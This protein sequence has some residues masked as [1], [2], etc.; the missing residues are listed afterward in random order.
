MQ[1]KWKRRWQRLAKAILPPMAAGLLLLSVY[2]P[3]LANPTGGTVT[4]GA[5]NI[6]TSGSTTTINQTTN[7]VAINWQSF[8]IGKGETVTFV[9]P[10]ATSV[11]L[12]RVV[13]SDASSIYG[14]LNA[15]GRVYLINPNGIL[16]APG[17]QVNTGGLVA[18]TL[19]ISDSDFMNGN[20]VFEKNGNAGSVINQG[21]ITAADHAVLIG[22]VV[23]N[24]GVIAAQ[25][26]GL[27][28]GDKV[29]LDFNGDKL[30]NVTVNTGALNG[31]AT[32]SG[33]ICADGG[34]VVMSAGTKDALLNTV[35]NN[36][37]VI[38]A[39]SV[40]NV[41]GVIRLEGGT[42]TNRGTLDASG[43][44]SGQTG[45]TVKVLGNTVTLTSGS[46]IDVSGNAGGG[47][48][49]IGGA[50]QCGGSEYTAT[51]TT[52]E[53]GVT[54]TADAITTGNG[55]TVVVWANDTTTFAGTITARGGSVSGNGGNVET[56]G[57]KSLKVSGT[58]LAGATKGKNGSWLLDPEDLTVDATAASTISNSLN[59][60]TDVTLQTS[61][62]TASGTGT[63]TGG[64]NGDITINAPLAWAT[65]TGTL[66][67]SAY[68]NINLNSSISGAHGGLTLAA[69]TSGHG[70]GITTGIIIPANSISV[71]L[72]TLQSGTWREINSSLSS[73]YAKDFRIN[74]GTFIRAKGGTGASGDPYQIADVYGL[75]GI[76]SAGMLDKHYTLTN[77]INA[78]S[79]QYWY[80]DGSGNYS[81]FMPIG[82]IATAYTGFTG[83]FS[84]NDHQISGLYIHRTTLKGVGLF[85]SLGASG[86]SG[87]AISHVGLTGGN[88]TG[89]QYV[90]GLV[91]ANFYS[92]ATIENSY[93]AG[94][95]SGTGYRIGGLIGTNFSTVTSSYSA[96]SVSSPADYVGGLV[97]ENFGTVT[98]S[99]HTGGTVSGN[100]YLG[101]LIGYNQSGNPL[102]SCYNTGVVTGS[103]NVGGLV[104]SNI[105]SA[106]TNSYNAGKVTGSNEY[107]GGLV[108]YNNSSAITNSYNA[109]AVTG[110]TDYVGGLA[111][112]NY[113]SSPITNS[114]NTGAVTGGTVVG[115]LAGFNYSSAINNSYNAGAVTGS[116]SLIGGLVGYNNSA[117]ITNSYNTGKVTGNGTTGGL[118]GFN[119]SSGTITNSYST[120]EV[121]GNGAGGLVGQNDGTITYSYWDMD[122]SGQTTGIAVGTTTGATGLTTA[123]WL[124]NG[125]IAAGLWDTTSTWVAGYPYPVL[126]ALPYIVV[127]GTG[128]QVYGNTSSLAAAISGI[129]DQNGNNAAGLVNTSGISWLSNPKSPAGTGV[130]GGSGATVT[131]AGYQ[132]TY[133]GTLTVNTATLTITASDAS[134]IYGQTAA[135]SG[136]NVSGLVNS[137]SVSS[138]TLTSAGSGATANKGTYSITA[139]NASGTGLGNYTISYA[140]GT[141]TVNP[142]T[143][144]ITASDA[145]KTYGQTA[146]LNGYSVSGLLNSDSVSSVTLTSA[147]SGATANT[148]TY[149]ITGSDA[150]GIGLNNYDI[151][152]ANGTLTINPA[153]LTITAS[154]ASKTYGQ[155]AALNGYSVSGLLN[156]DSVS[157]VTLTSAGT[158]ATA[159]TGTY[160][161]TG[162]DANGIGL[163]NY[164]ISY[165]NGTLTVNPATLTVTASDA[166]KTYGQTA[167]LSGYSVSGLLNSDSVSSVTLTSAGSAAT[168]NTGTY[169]ITGSDASGTGL[170]N[171]IISYANGTL[172]VNPAHL[173]VI[174]NN[175]AKYAGQANPAFTAS[176]SGLANGDS[177][178][179]LPGALTFD[180]AA[181]TA[182]DPGTYAINLTGTLFSPNY[183]ISYVN[184]VLTVSGRTTNPAYDSAVIHAQ[185]T[186]FPLSGSSQPR[187]LSAY[188]SPLSGYMAGAAGTYVPLTIRGSGI[189]TDGYAPWTWL[190]NFGQTD[191]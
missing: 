128:T 26:T 164:D 76:G 35:V 147:G 83:T 136:Y 18:S 145:S 93:Y 68:N 73:F 137:D 110:S 40:N 70:D 58:V 129:T 112:S 178:A 74:G 97:G 38:R 135:L 166:S 141:L 108:G 31:S 42:V 96:G 149:A 12:N 41:N 148:G 3:V 103:G 13:G 8:N 109:G 10:S 59:S 21:T 172:T 150:N 72:F 45:G 67:L 133:N 16:F 28:A 177:P 101:G 146:A 138:V 104:G 29:S 102:T 36:S 152:Y 142:A 11:A 15:N 160:A 120:G 151:S 17:A 130:F 173:T 126:K 62:T 175:A 87:A 69:N 184:G 106:I 89:W 161:I 113:L 107:V 24:E 162:S 4:S 134:K 189:N 22:P 181:T 99:H 54:I 9:Q 20:Y 7:K 39:Q 5:A 174:A 65:G 119:I 159:N 157:S 79:T 125:P 14:A 2:N 56:S 187:P 80:G 165:A 44:T 53:N 90:G 51:N 43:K 132:L 169:A 144:T 81:G 50:Y 163:N 47:T 143:L 118:V 82:T 34:L 190:G 139:A 176:Y 37:G 78:S 33:S 23:K 61:S 19:N 188:W 6:S 191:N 85:G 71:A 127:T 183:T 32:N 55:G 66:T 158:G 115:G 98:S 170:G 100:D 123:E 52:V 140:N 186:A 86:T 92:G 84:G 77:D 168:A 57:K 124:T 114:Y 171:Y 153:T 111:G 105:S 27:A 91:G 155:T 131:T 180:T 94:T 49:L 25:V 122:T 75:Q 1:R 185:Q 48:A 156:S 46:N 30:L 95:V 63:I 167:A 121:T 154:D 116:N 182:S 88:V 64:G 60:N 179:S 117:A